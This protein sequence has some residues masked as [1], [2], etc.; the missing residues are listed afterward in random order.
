MKIKLT[1]KQAKIY[2]NKNSLK[3][4]IIKKYLNK[5]YFEI[6]KYEIKKLKKNQNKNFK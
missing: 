4:R 2:T 5:K 6:N 3:K 1:A